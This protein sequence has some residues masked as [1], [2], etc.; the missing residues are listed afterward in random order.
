[1]ENFRLFTQILARVNPARGA[2]MRGDGHAAPQFEAVGPK[3]RTI[4]LNTISYRIYTIL[5]IK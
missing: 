1:M 4:V 3:A 5:I 2:I